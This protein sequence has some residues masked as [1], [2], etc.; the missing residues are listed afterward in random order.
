MMAFA[1]KVRTLP[2][3]SQEMPVIHLMTGRSTVLRFLSQPKKVVIGNQNYFSIEFI[4]SDITLQ[5]LSNT[6]SN[7]FVYG[8]GFTYGF[9]L[10]VDHSSDYDDLVFVRNK[11]PNFSLPAPPVKNAAKIE[12]SKKDLRFSIL[13]SKKEKFDVEGGTF[14]W[15][16]SIKSYFADVFILTKSKKPISSNSMKIQI[17]AN[18]EDLTT[19]KAVFEKD[20]LLPKIKNRVRIFANVS[21]K[22]NLSLKLQYNKEEEVFNLKWKK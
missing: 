14:K 15:N 3:N 17:L 12:P 7:L 8:D 21:V 13:S 20:E 2:T 16:E 1:G 6:T 11:V 19:I 22:Q 5:P 9:I 4:D 10:K 18:N